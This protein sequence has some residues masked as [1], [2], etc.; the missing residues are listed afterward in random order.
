M[1]RVD[2]DDQTFSQRIRRVLGGKK[3]Y[4][5]MEKMRSHLSARDVLHV[6]ER[7]CV[8]FY[9]DIWLRSLKIFNTQLLMANK[10][11]CWP[12]YV[13]HYSYICICKLHLKRPVVKAWVQFHMH[14]RKQQPCNVMSMQFIHSEKS[15]FDPLTFKISINCF[16]KLQ[17]SC[18]LLLNWVTGDEHI[19]N[20]IKH[21]LGCWNRM[22]IYALEIKHWD[23]RGSAFPLSASLQNQQQI[24]R[25]GSLLSSETTL[26]ETVTRQQC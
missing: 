13:D 2:G 10:K 6:S 5:G 17:K 12:H 23:G 20:Q 25:N 1:V 18:W 8:C 21:L 19:S 9:W 4:H 11:N 26:S 15:G 7:S 3:L 22:K 16:L 14:L 24:N